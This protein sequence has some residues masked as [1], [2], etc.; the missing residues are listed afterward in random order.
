MLTARTLAIAA[1]TRAGRSRRPG[2]PIDGGRTST[3]TRRRGRSIARAVAAD[4][5]ATRHARNRGARDRSSSPSA[6]AADRRS[7]LGRRQVDLLGQTRGLAAECHRGVPGRSAA[8]SSRVRRRRARR[9]ARPRRW[10]ARPATATWYAARVHV[11]T[12]I[13]EWCRD[14]RGPACA[15]S[16]RCPGGPRP[17]RVGLR[18]RAA[19]RQ[20][21][22][23]SVFA[24]PRW[25]SA[26]AAR[27]RVIN[28]V[29]TCSSTAATWTSRRRRGRGSRRHVVLDRASPRAAVPAGRR[30]AASRDR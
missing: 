11:A 5:A 1:A 4:P 20:G 24:L 8:R 25:S 2:P 17:A 14:R 13:D 10:C 3:T 28:A 27:R 26:R 22:P 23:P 6:K 12:A 19:G 18:R 7:R 30:P 9:R 16:N 15:R 21:Y 29:Y